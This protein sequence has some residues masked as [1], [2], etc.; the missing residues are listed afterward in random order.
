MHAPGPSSR[1]WTSTLVL[2]LLL[3]PT[4][5]KAGDEARLY[6]RAWY[7][8]LFADAPA[9]S[10]L[11]RRLRDVASKA[12]G[13]DFDQAERLLA[14]LKLTPAQD[15]RFLV[16]VFDHQIRKERLLLLSR[17]RASGM[18]NELAVRSLLHDAWLMEQ[19]PT[20]IQFTALLPPWRARELASFHGFV[21]W[22]QTC[23]GF[24][25]Q[26]EPPPNASVCTAPPSFP[27]VLTNDEARLVYLLILG[28]LQSILGNRRQTTEAHDAGRLLAQTHGWN[29]AVGTLK[30]RP[31]DLAL[32]L[33]GSLPLLGLRINDELVEM[34]STLTGNRPRGP[35]PDEFAQGERAY[36]QAA[37]AFARCGTPGE[38]LASLRLAALGNARGGAQAEQAWLKVAHTARVARNQRYLLMATAMHGLLTSSPD[39]VRAALAT[40][41]QRHDVGGAISLAEIGMEL[42]FRRQLAGELGRASLTLETIAQGLEGS[43]LGMEVAP[44]LARLQGKRTLL[45]MDQGMVERAINA[46]DEGIHQ[47]RIYTRRLEQA[48]D[49]ASPVARQYLETILSF[50]RQ[51]ELILLQ[52]TIFQ[53]GQAIGLG[54]VLEDEATRR[55]QEYAAREQEVARTVQGGLPS[56]TTVR[57]QKWRSLI[58]AIQTELHKSSGDCSAWL[59]IHELHMSQLEEPESETVLE[60]LGLRIQLLGALAVCEPETYRARAVQALEA[61]RPIEELRASRSLD[62]GSDA[63]RLVA[64]MNAQ[65]RLR[66][67]L[68]MALV[69]GE[70]DVAEAWLAAA[71]PLLTSVPRVVL[72]PAEWVV[73]EARVKVRRGR[74]QQALQL[75]RPWLQDPRASYPELPMVLTVFIDASAQEAPE[76]ALLAWERRQRILAAQAWDRIGVTPAQ[77]GS[78]ERASLE[79]RLAKTGTLSRS[80]LARLTALRKVLPTSEFPDAAARLTPKRLGQLSR[81]LPEG[82]AI[83]VF[84]LTDTDE[85]LTWVLRREQPLQTRRV[86][87]VRGMLFDELTELSSS[88]SASAVEWKE[89]AARLYPLFFGEGPQVAPG[90]RMVIA[91]SEEL[92]RTLFEA[93]AA[94]GEPPLA[95]RFPV[96]RTDHLFEDPQQTLPKALRRP[97]VFVGF[98]GPGLKYAEE[99]VRDV[100]KQLRTPVTLLDGPKATRTR[101]LESITGAELIHVAAHGRIDST[102]SVASAFQVAG[103]AP[104]EAFALFDATRSA[105]LVVFSACDTLASGFGALAHWGG[106]RW[107]ITTPRAVQDQRAISVMK[108]FY[109]HLPRGEPASALHAARRQVAEA[110]QGPEGHA[111]TDFLLSVRSAEAAF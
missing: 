22:L 70:L 82:S 37:R 40:F 71:K 38:L 24:V 48:R 15:V 63:S 46:A 21:A 56:Q 111:L 28:D 18:M 97:P 57:Y 51:Q 108:S 102:N 5:S 11:E 54:V 23:E 45:Y 68:N 62:G 96:V 85:L 59:R 69:L 90:G 86:R 83:Y 33:P 109:R 65:L 74:N 34:R 58:A 101:I 84:H 2:L 35:G 93:L 81:G 30:A 47:V 94:S 72:T 3:V 61:L 89:S 104:L 77:P 91:T 29:C 107:A 64:S 92:S 50:V 16:E 36:T 87:V 103:D 44:T 79:N 67:A 60:P 19:L 8:E 98:N 26:P 80:E 78:A 49:D 10:D 17:T 43:G 55:A 52:Q 66:L 6:V 4:P 14:P 25:T 106:A 95:L 41:G 12:I 75:L 7:P 39:P 105:N 73:F 53:L 99:E 20:F 31:G 76:Q 88:L 100:V 13:G 110:G 9:Q 1:A 42:A 32:G 27:D